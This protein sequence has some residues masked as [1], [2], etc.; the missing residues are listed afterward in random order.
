[1]NAGFTKFKDPLSV[2]FGRYLCRQ[3]LAMSKR[4]RNRCLA[5]A[6][7]GKTVCRMHGGKST[8]PNTPDGLLRLSRAKMTHGTQTR[9]NRLG[10]RVAMLA[11]REQEKI[12]LT[13]GFT[14]GEKIR[15]RK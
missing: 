11:L 10:H 4:S 9:K 3:C 13:N 2:V 8:G 7:S 12:A 5:P 1:M 6:V 15:G 14:W